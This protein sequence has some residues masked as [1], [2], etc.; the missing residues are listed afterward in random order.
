MSDRR[1]V[2]PVTNREAPGLLIRLLKWLGDRWQPLTA[3]LALL[4]STWSAYV[5]YQTVVITR[6]IQEA[7]L[8][9]QSISRA[10][11]L[12]IGLNS[13]AGLI[14]ASNYGSGVANIYQ[15]DLSYS[16]IISTLN[17]NQNIAERSDISYKF[18]KES[19][20]YFD[21]D[22]EERVNRFYFTN[23]VRLITPLQTENFFGF[24]I[25][26]KKD[27]D[28]ERL[29]SYFNS[30]DIRVCYTD[31]TG[32]YRAAVFSG[33]VK[34]EKFAPCPHELDTTQPN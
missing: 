25:E 6:L 5:G 15:V 23:P 21:K 12:G 20:S 13:S 14:T 8:R 31:I 28:E 2:R 34:R 11:V 32:D 9:S 30:I 7:E 24:K 18:L 26:N 16:G 4:V 17:A 29:L 1:R 3:I 19:M 33:D 10:P 27:D 22:L